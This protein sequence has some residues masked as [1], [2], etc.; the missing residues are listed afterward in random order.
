MGWLGRPG[1]PRSSSR[2]RVQRIF[3]ADAKKSVSR[4]STSGCGLSG[5]SQL[6]VPDPPSVSRDES[7]SRGDGAIADEVLHGSRRP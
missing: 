3:L 6:S 2:Q 7:L 1:P 5:P 4:P